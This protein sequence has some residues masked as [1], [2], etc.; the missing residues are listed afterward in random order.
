MSLRRQALS[1]FFWT[2]SERFLLKG[3]GFIVSIVLTRILLPEDF[4]LLGMIYLFTGIATVL[5]NSGLT[6]SLIRSKELEQ[7]DYSTVFLANLAIALGVYGILF[8]TAPYIA[9]F[10]EQDR[11]T[12][13]IRIYCLIL[14][15]DSFSIVPRTRLTI[16]LN[17]K[18][19]ML[20]ALPALLI[21]SAL[22]VYLAYAGYG[23]WALIYGPLSYSFLQALQYWLFIPWRPIGPFSQERLK[24]H[25]GFGYKL[26][27]SGLINIGFNNIYYV[28]IGKLFRLDQVG[29]YQRAN[30][31]KELPVSNL[32]MVLDKITFPLFSKIQNEGGALKGAYKQVMSLILFVF[33]PFIAIAIVVAEPVVVI[34]YT[35]KW[36]MLVPYLKIL[37]LASVLEPIKVYHVN[38]MKIKGRSDQ[39]LLATALTRGISLIFII[40]AAFYGIMALLWTQ[41]ATAVVAYL[42]YARMSGSHIDYPTTEQIRDLLPSLFLASM[43]GFALFG[44]DQVL[45]ELP[46]LARFVILVLIGGMLYWILANL[47]RISSLGY[48][49]QLISDRK[50][51]KG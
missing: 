39:V 14:V 2:F 10:Y 1:G 19:Q 36:I 13:I 17:F 44:L 38:I 5:I 40:I 8:L 47:F 42:V 33:A 51:T 20:I 6:H 31:L 3:V 23:V 22:S 35:E 41:V 11:L 25:W 9:Q 46:P 21:S 29:Y 28:V 16:A 50:G 15:F 7:Q 26:T 32:S 43:M 48:I 30:T 27:L 18:R 45:P 34:L 49:K 4:G 37:L 12:D 24:K